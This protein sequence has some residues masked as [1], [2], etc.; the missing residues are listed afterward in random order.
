MKRSTTILISIVAAAAAAALSAVPASAST[1]SPASGTFTSLTVTITSTR[2]DGGN[3]FVT[4][5]RTAALAGTFTGPATETDTIVFHSDG[6]TIVHGQGM[7]ACTAD[8]V[9]GT[10]SYRIESSGTF[11]TSV[12]GQYVAHGSGGLAGL[13]AEGP[14][15]GN[16]AAVTYGG[17]EHFG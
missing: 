12:S 9:S 11:P 5:N 16:F 6:T 13:H 14:F 15:S 1:S 10:L 4:A 17:Q 7:C 3:T 8:G 2:T